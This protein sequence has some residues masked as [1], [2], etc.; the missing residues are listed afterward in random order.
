MERQ[1]NG[2]GKKLDNLWFH[3]GIADRENESAIDFS[4]Q[5]EEIHTDDIFDFKSEIYREVVNDFFFFLDTEDVV[6]PSSLTK[7]SFFFGEAVSR[8]LLLH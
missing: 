8:N 7:R 6:S 1:L 2:S 3:I 5:C 4:G